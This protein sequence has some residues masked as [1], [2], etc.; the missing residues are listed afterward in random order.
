MVQLGNETLRLA[1]GGLIIDANNRSVTHSQLPV[2]ADVLYRV[3]RNGE[4]LRI[5]VLTPQEQARLDSSK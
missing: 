4:I 1:P 2:G 5:I 3:D